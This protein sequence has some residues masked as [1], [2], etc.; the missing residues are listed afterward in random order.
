MLIVEGNNHYCPDNV[1]SRGGGGGGGGGFKE[2]GSFLPK[3]QS[4]PQAYAIKMKKDS[5]MS[6]KLVSTVA[7][8]TTRCPLRALKI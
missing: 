3:Q 6:L 2:A 7:S 4:F 1:S 5:F 8:E